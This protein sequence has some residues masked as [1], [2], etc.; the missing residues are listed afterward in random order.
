MALSPDCLSEDDV[1]AFA[2]G[3]LASDALARVERHLASCVDCSRWLAEV[4][5]LTPSG[6]DASRSEP[7]IIVEEGASVGRYVIERLVGQGAMGCVYAA[8]DPELDR[9]VALKILNARAYAPDLAARLQREAKAMARISHS[10]VITVYDAGR[11][12]DQLF[13]AM[14]LVDGGTLRQWLAEKPRPWRDIVDVFVRAGRG[15]AQA[16]DAGL[17]HRDFKPDNVLVGRDGRVRVT[18][19][20]LARVVREEPSSDERAAEGSDGEADEAAPDSGVTRTGVLL[21]TPAYM[22]PEQLGGATPD[23]RSDIFS[24]C[25]A[26]YEALYGE[27]PFAGK[28]MRELLPEKRGNLVRPEP[29]G[30]SVPPRL[31]R[32]L[33]AGLRA[34]PAERYASMDECLAAVERAARPSRAPIVAG[35][36]ALAAIAAIALGVPALRHARDAANASSS[37]APSS[38]VA[39]RGDCN[40]A[41]VAAHGGAPFVCRASDGACVAVASDDCTPTFEP[42]DLGADDTV[43]IGAMFPTKGPGAETHGAMNVAGTELARQEI[44]RSTS[45][46]VGS[47]ASLHVPRIALVAC[48][49]SVDPMRAARH[50]VDDV[51]VPAILGFDSGQEIVDVAGSYL[52]QHDVLTVAS[53]TTSPLV[54]RLPR[55]AGVPPLV[56]RTTFN[57]ESVADATAQMVHAFDLGPKTI[58]VSL[59]HGDS[60]AAQAFAERLYRKLIFNGKSAMDNAGDYQEIAFPA[61]AHQP[62]DVARVVDAIVQ[63]SPAIVIALGSYQMTVPIVAGV[64]AHWPAGA[65]R[66]TYLV[67]NDTL[68]LFA[69][70]LGDDVDR[71]RRLFTIE[72]L[73]GSTPN[74]RFVIRYN[75]THAKPV[76]ATF[77]PGSTYDAFY[78]LAYATFA[79]G[80]QPAHGATLARAFSRLVPP[81]AP[82]DVGPTGVFDAITALSK[83]GSIDLQGTQS[84][85]D[86]DLT[87]GEAPTDFALLCAAVDV[88]GRA[89]GHDVESGV[90]YRA[91][92]HSIDGVMRCP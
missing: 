69:P 20:G 77:N 58:R 74:A 12:G 52:I 92:T 83:G 88:K 7:A 51:G 16:H 34:D 73:S 87:T 22:A 75:A 65:P 80:D 10:E 64:E 78:L 43:W 79:L 36:V 45:A 27:R 40:R 41:C 56:W 14:E 38:S 2:D 50:L 67:P 46:L 54:T 89:D 86:F 28:T 57:L 33:L 15:L 19:F 26:L 1:L 76:T 55:P 71:R 91:R 90:V 53:L 44:A 5:R 66:P 62:A 63:K 25:V 84:D 23:V 21:G 18:D 85:L 72:S 3:R 30:T 8:R 31:R 70:F 61:A 60:V 29:A 47:G 82:I 68:E 37:S 59:A 11:H 32:A 13:I 49:D 6:D 81:G 48:D 24:F 35:A 42:A 4:A 39:A 9:V 17:V